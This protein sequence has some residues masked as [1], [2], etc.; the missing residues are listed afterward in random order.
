MKKNI[1]I[2]ML[3]MAIP[4]LVVWGGWQTMTKY[5][6][7]RTVI[8][9]VE[10]VYGLK[11]I[12]IIK[13]KGEKCEGYLFSRRW[14]AVTVSDGKRIVLEGDLCTI[15]KWGSG[16]IFVKGEMNGNTQPLP[17]RLREEL[18]KRCKA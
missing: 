12:Q 16:G 3:I 1:A 14:R 4:V 15:P 5:M 8:K 18:F 6:V 11:N 7:T 17:T 13:E 10:K 2:A 9:H